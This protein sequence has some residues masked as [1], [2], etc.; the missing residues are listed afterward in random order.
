[1]RSGFSNDEPMLRWSELEEKFWIIDEYGELMWF[2]SVVE[3]QQAVIETRV[4]QAL[5][6]E[7]IAIIRWAKDTSHKVDR[8]SLIA[9]LM[10]RPAAQ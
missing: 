10:Q 4:R 6:D 5:M 7:Y 8:R 9:F 2:D 3:G 1:M